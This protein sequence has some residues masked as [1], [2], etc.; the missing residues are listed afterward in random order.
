[1]SHLLRAALFLFPVRLLITALLL[2]WGFRTVRTRMFGAQLCMTAAS[3][4]WAWIQFRHD[5]VL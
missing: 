1:M 3:V 5:F 4:V 2:W